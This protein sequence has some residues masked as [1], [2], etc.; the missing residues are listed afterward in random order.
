MFSHAS[1]LELG[2]SYFFCFSSFCA[3]QL[4]L[5][6]N[7]IQ[8]SDFYYDMEYCVEYSTFRTLLT[9]KTI[10]SSYAYTNI[11]CDLNNASISGKPVNTMIIF[12]RKT[13]K[14]LGFTFEFGM[15]SFQCFLILKRNRMYKSMLLVQDMVIFHR[16][17]ILLLQYLSYRKSE[18]ISHLITESV[19]A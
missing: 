1:F 4:G 7:S 16:I 17:Q 10:S 9:G 6:P 13:A 19:L 3:L 15:N 14:P 8:P 12:S 11:P 2:I 5:Q 18:I